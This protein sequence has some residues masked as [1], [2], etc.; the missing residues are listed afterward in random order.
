MRCSLNA[1][2]F[3]QS[4][5][6]R[7]YLDALSVSSRFSCFSPR[8]QK[9]NPLFCVPTRTGY[10]ANWVLANLQ[11]MCPDIGPRLA[12]VCRL[13][14]SGRGVCSLNLASETAYMVRLSIVASRRSTD[15]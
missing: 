3:T 11:F 12:Y 15:E 13:R 2:Q 9:S 1:P 14:A 10:R 4:V 6:N 8:K 7:E 5:Y